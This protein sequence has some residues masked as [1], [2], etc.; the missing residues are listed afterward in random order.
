M[1]YLANPSTPAVQAAM[2]AGQLGAIT[3]PSQGNAIPPGVTYGADNGCFGAGYPGDAAWLAWLAARAAAPGALARCVW[4]TAPDVVGD[5]SATLER[6][7]PHL[8]RIRELGYPAALVAQNGLT[9]ERTPWG[10]F[11]VLF[12]GGSPE[13]RPCGTQPPPKRGRRTSAPRCPDCGAL[14]TEWKCSADAAALADAASSRGVPVHMGRVNSLR[15]WRVAEVMGCATVD[16]TFLTFG[17]D[18]RL[19][20]LLSWSSTPALF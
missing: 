3:T 12:L 7:A 18:R 6:S 1:L 8:P 15:R 16:G 14:V 13:C 2:V 4:A 10:A 19:P 17:P 9:P 5:W 11:D 20:E